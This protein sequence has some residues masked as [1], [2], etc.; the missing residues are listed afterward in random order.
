MREK[1]KWLPREDWLR[2]HNEYLRS[3][4]WRRLRAAVLSRDGGTCRMCETAA[5]TQVHH[6]TYARWRHERDF[7]LVSV[8]DECHHDQH[9]AGRIEAHELAC[10]MCG[11]TWE[12]GEAK[13][14]LYLSYIRIEGVAT[15]AGLFCNL[16]PHCNTNQYKSIYAEWMKANEKAE[17]R[18]DNAPMLLDV[19]AQWA[20]GPWAWTQTDSLARETWSDDAR[21]GYTW[22]LLRLSQMPNS[23]GTPLHFGSGGD[24]A[25]EI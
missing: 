6:L 3:D 18:A 14:G 11:K 13:H 22:A 2:L 17:N 9:R 4:K 8:C 25:E 12:A 10:D 23:G 7:D 1:Q 5:A 24:E 20:M 21:V 16:K 15:I 19:P